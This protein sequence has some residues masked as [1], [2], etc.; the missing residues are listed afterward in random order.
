MCSTFE[1]D[2]THVILSEEY[3]SIKKDVQSITENLKKI[4]NKVNDKEC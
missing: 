3:R 4:S 2:Y 1:R